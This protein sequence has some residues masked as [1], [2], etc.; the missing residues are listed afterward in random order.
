MGIK[1]ELN[2]NWGNEVDP[3][4]LAFNQSRTAIMCAFQ[5][6]LEDINTLREEQKRMKE[7]LRVVAYPKRGTYEELEKE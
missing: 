3:K 2:R 4:A 7:L 5:D 6:L 1:M